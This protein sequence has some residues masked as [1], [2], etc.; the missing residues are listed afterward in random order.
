MKLCSILNILID[1]CEVNNGGCGQNTVC[2]HEPETFAVKC[3]CAP[4]FVNV[5]EGDNLKC[6]GNYA[7]ILFG[8]NE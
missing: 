3:A 4:G 5:G 2:S 7:D 8:G 1:A 6:E